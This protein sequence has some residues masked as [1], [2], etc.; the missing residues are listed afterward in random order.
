VGSLKY[1]IQG[2]L[3]TGKEKKQ[4]EREKRVHRRHSHLQPRTTQESTEAGSTAEADPPSG[5][6]RARF[7]DDPT[8]TTEGKRKSG[9]TSGKKSRPN[10]RRAYPPNVAD[11]AAQHGLDVDY[12]SNDSDRGDSSSEQSFTSGSSESSDPDGEMG[13]MF[14]D[15]A[16]VAKHQRESEEHRR[17]SEGAHEP[18]VDISRLHDD[19]T[20]AGLLQHGNPMAGQNNKPSAKRFSY[21]MVDV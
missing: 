21:N 1:E 3:S 17:S 18:L 19:S 12:S 8:S 13:Q 9:K 7:A 5:K 2:D 6:Q 11:V 14:R 15:T 16:R 20:A 4:K 10:S